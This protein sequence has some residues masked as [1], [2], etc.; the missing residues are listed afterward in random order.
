M[1]YIKDQEDF[2]TYYQIYTSSPIVI[3]TTPIG[4]YALMTFDKPNRK[5]LPSRIMFALKNKGATSFTV[6]PNA[7]IG[8]IG[9][10]YVDLVANGA[11]TLN[12]DNTT[13]TINSI[14]QFNT[15]IIPIAETATG[16]YSISNGTTIYLNVTSAGSNGS[17]FTI[18]FTIEGFCVPV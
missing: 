2:S 18:V 9:P 10:S 1:S 8:A 3:D 12:F 15:N 11:T 6:S 17:D 5:F 7:S 4:T 16:V 14:G 13:S